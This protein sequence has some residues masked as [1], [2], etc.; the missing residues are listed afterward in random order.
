MNINK[1]KL[2]SILFF[3]NVGNSGEFFKD[4]GD[5]AEDGADGSSDSNE[6]SVK[7]IIESNLRNTNFAPSKHYTADFKIGKP[8]QNGSGGGVLTHLREPVLFPRKDVLPEIGGFKFKLPDQDLRDVL[9]NNSIPD[10]VKAKLYMILQRKYARAKTDNGDGRDSE[11]EEGDDYDG[12]NTD[13]SSSRRILNKVIA[14]LHSSHGVKAYR[15]AEILMRERK[16]VRWDPDGNITH[17]V[18]RNIGSFDLST[19]VKTIIQA[20]KNGREKNVLIAARIVKP[21]FNKLVEDRVIGNKL[22]SKSLVKTKPQVAA[23]YIAW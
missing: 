22:L 14:K 20:K 15:L 4:S 12:G 6:R 5:S 9:D 23:K 3:E 21:F 1:Y 19:L 2:V 18:I 17:P 16:S 11:F 8:V 7:D 10:E 13:N